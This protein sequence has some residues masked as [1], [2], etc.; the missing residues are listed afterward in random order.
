MTK[1]GAYPVESKTMAQRMKCRNPDDVYPK[2]F[3]PAKGGASFIDL[4]EHKVTALEEGDEDTI[5]MVREEFRKKGMSGTYQIRAARGGVGGG[6]GIHSVKWGMRQGNVS[7][8]G[9]GFPLI[10]RE[11]VI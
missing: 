9:K 5:A 2:N 4:P 11:M 6:R 7:T 3:V 1:I 8:Q 10:V